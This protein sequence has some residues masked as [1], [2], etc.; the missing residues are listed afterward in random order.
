MSKA[1]SSND[2][3]VTRIKDLFEENRG[4]SATFRGDVLEKYVNNI[5]RSKWREYLNK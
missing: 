1:F 4:R 5:L 3:S 2:P